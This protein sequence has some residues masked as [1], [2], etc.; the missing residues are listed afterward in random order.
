LEFEQTP[1]EGRTSRGSPYLKWIDTGMPVVPAKFLDTVFFLYKS[2]ADAKAGKNA[3]GT[4]FFVA[5]PTED[6]LGHHY[7]VSN[8]HVAVRDGFSVIR[9]NTANGGVEII[10]LQ[11]DEWKD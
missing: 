4:G 2:E 9:M 1:V 11:P 8:Y 5:L 3:G 10:D 7:G 6:G